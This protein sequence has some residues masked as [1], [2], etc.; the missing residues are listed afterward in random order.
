M[1]ILKNLVLLVAL[2]FGANAQ[3][4]LFENFKNPPQSAKPVVWWHWTGSN[5]TKEGI[6]KDLEWM[7]RAGIGG[8]QAFDVSIGGGQAIEKKVKYLSPEWL[9]LIK[10]TAAEAERL[11]LE[12]TMVTAAGWSETGGTWVKPQEAMKKLV[13]SK[14][15]VIGGKPINII[16][17]QPPSVNG[18]I[19]NLPKRSGI[20]GGSTNDPTLYTDQ[21][22]MAFRTPENELETAM[23]IITNQKGEKINAQALIDDDLTTKITSDTPKKDSTVYLQYEYEKPITVRSF[24]IA[25]VGT[26]PYPSSFIRA[27]YVQASE[28]GK[29][30]KTLFSLPG[31]QHDIRALPVRTFSFSPITAKFFRVVFTQ[32][33]SNSTVGAPDEF[34]GFRQPTSPPKHFDLAEA[35]FSNEAKVNRWEE[36]ANFAPMFAFEHLQTAAVAASAVIKKD[37]ILNLTSKMKPD[38]SLDWDA[39]T[40]NWTIMRFGYSLTG[41]KNGPAMPDATGFEV[42]KLSKKHLNSYLTQWSNPIAEAIGKNF[43][44]SMKYYLVDS[45]E[46]DAQNWTDDMIA[47][48]KTRRGYDPI[49]FLP[50]LAGKIVESAEVSDRFLWDFRLTFAEMLVDNH[51]AAITEFA[52]KQGIKTYGEVAGISMPIIQD[53]LRTKNAVDIPMAEFGM[54]QGL[55]SGENKS[56]VSPADLENQK[57]YGGANDRLNA[58]QSDVREAASAAHV[59]GKKVV[60]AEAWTGG[61]YE[62]PA[63]MKFIGDYWLTQGINQI[64]FHT[65]AH[66][67][68]DTKPGN[69]MVGTHFHRNITW[70]EKAKPFVDYITRNQFLLQEGRSVADIAYYLGED[71]PAVVPY[72]KKLNYDVPEGYDYDFINTEILNRMEVKNGDLVLPSG[73][74]Y[75]ILVLPEK[76]TMTPQVLAKIT[77]LVGNG[78]TI[79]GP[80]PSKSPSLIG[81]PKVDEVITNKA[82][83]LWGNADGQ[84]IFQNNF[85]QGKVFWNVPLIGILAQLGLKKDVEYT[86][87][88]IDT[89]LSWIHRKTTDADYYFMLNMRTHPEDLEVNFRIGGKAPELWYADKGISK[90]LSYS[91]KNGSTTVKLHL[92]PQ[93]AAFVVFQNNATQNEWVA[94][95]KPTKE[96]LKIENNWKVSFSQNPTKEIHLDKLISWSNLEQD[97]LKYFSGTATYSHDFVLTAK[98]LKTNQ[99]LILDLGKVKDIATVFINGKEVETLWKAPYQIDISSFAKIGKNTLQISVINQWDNRIIGDKTLPKEKKV[100]ASLPMFGVSQK[101]KDAGLMSEVVLRIK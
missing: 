63:D 26:S 12:M 73:M 70:A 29:T 66:Q 6:T 38:G 93:E 32:G 47:E 74:K 101:L 81:Y 20:G 42:D 4:L 90:P 60:G 87:P 82:N 39:P 100:L 65:S 68:L 89:R 21:I 14:T 58:H 91:I 8:F 23:P 97:E 22:V 9:D 55:G 79:V 84:L 76:A 61:G 57:A 43:G 49:P 75:K 77:E 46:A 99:N 62:A 36:K 25:Y 64:I 71:I 54:A 48:F 85:G 72:W 30:Y 34:G 51:Y 86:K 7:Q 95:E 24:S 19:R 53:A 35:V 80:K 33:G 16:L 18:F 67:P 11:G 15:Q 13:W 96:I 59:Y 37:E 2:S 1:K 28:D 78:A 83:E 52:H 40:G 88:N 44:K 27:G 69:T 50:A 17:P 94:I 41:S 31:S 56:W 98:Q 45:Y 92:E 3:N 10:H 5:V